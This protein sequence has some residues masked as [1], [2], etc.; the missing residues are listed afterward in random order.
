MFLLT[1]LFVMDGCSIN[2]QMMAMMIRVI[3]H[4]SMIACALKWQQC[5][6]H[7]DCF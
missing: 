3:R 1:V 5:D 2:S 7:Y 4:V 6:E